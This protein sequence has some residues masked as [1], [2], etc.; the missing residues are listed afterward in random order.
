VFAEIFVS[1]LQCVVMSSHC[2]DSV[3][4]FATEIY[5]LFDG[6]VREVETRALVVLW[7][8]DVTNRKLRK[9]CNETCSKIEGLEQHFKYCMR[10]EVAR[11]CSRACQLRHWR[12]GHHK[13]CFKA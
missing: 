9:C 12:K 8:T 5:K 2:H 7:R 1:E 11:Y 13:M 10:C 3:G 6:Q 4:E